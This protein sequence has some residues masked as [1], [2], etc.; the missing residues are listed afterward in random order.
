MAS[1]LSLAVVAS[2]DTL[3]CAR[4]VEGMTGQRSDAN[5]LLRIIGAANLVT[6]LL[7]GISGGVSVASSTASFKGGARTSLSLLV[8]SL[9]I[10]AAVVA[11]APLLGRLPLVVVG[12]V[13]VVTAIQLVDRWSLELLR[14]GVSGEMVDWRAIALDLAV[15]VTVAATAIAGDIVVAVLI[16]VGVA[17]L[18]FVL[19]MS[20]SIVRHEQYGDRV[21]SRRSRDAADSELLASHGRSILLLELDGPVFFGSAESLAERIESALERGA[22]YVILDM[23][24]VSDLDSTGARV[25]LQAQERLRARGA[26][27]VL[28][29]ADAT[30]HVN[31]VLRDAG[32]VSAVTSAHVFADADRALEW[33]ENHLIEAM[34][35]S[36]ARA[37]EYPFV[38]LDLLAGFTAEERESFRALLA[39]REYARGDTVFREGGAGDELYVIVKGSAS[40]KLRMTDDQGG[41]EQR[42]ITFASGTAFGEMALLDREVRSASV[43]ADEPLVCYVLERAGYDKITREM[44]PIAIK[45]L[46]NLGRELSAR[47]RRANRMLN[48]QER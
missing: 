43:V 28:A 7:G 40:V 11:L 15:I 5:R 37:G 16:G 6:P 18:L 46:T 21:R 8:H 47:L 39:R 25:L 44:H 32:V 14:K 38:Q 30:A 45:L 26:H 1:A 27:L 4:I 20:R 17:V 3:I 42:L 48:Q 24:R 13:L 33:S 19:R 22:R 10:F 2:L 36:E 23:K 29:S 34:R 35:S 9:A 12:A 41:R 31:V